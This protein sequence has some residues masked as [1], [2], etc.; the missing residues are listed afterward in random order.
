MLG[1]RIYKK[2]N[3]SLRNL[4]NIYLHEIFI[5]KKTNNDPIISLEHFVDIDSLIGNNN[6]RGVG[7]NSE[8]K[9]CRQKNNIVKNSILPGGTWL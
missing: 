5:F 3:H 8:K 4:N 6:E 2:N 1:L 7:F 9:T